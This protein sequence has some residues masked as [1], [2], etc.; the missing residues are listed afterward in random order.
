MEGAWVPLA[1]IEIIFLRTIGSGEVSDLKFADQL[2]MSKKIKPEIEFASKSVLRIS[3]AILP[4]AL[5]VSDAK[6]QTGW[7]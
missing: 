7:A 5:T 6:S 4:T 3:F 1:E 2:D